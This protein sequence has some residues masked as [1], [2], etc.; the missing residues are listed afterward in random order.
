[1]K[2]E[3]SP[4][5]EQEAEVLEGLKMKRIVS[6]VVI[7]LAV[8][9]CAGYSQTIT[10]VVEDANTGSGIANARIYVVNQNRE[11]FSAQDGSYQ[12]NNVN[13]NVEAVICCEAFGYESRQAFTLAGMQG[14]VFRDF[15]LPPL[16]PGTISGVIRDAFDDPVN[17]A[18]ISAYS[19][20]DNVIATSTSDNNGEY[21]L[22]LPHGHAYRIAAVSDPLLGES[23]VTVEAEGEHTLDIVIADS[24]GMVTGPD[25]YGYI[26]VENQDFHPLAPVYNWIAN[27][28]LEGGPGTR[29]VIP[30]EPNEDLNYIIDLPFTFTFYGLDYDHITACENGM[31]AFGA[32]ADTTNP[33]NFSNTRIPS[34][35]GGPPA[36][37]APFWED[38]R[39]TLT[40]LSHY[41][42]EENGT[43]IIEWYNS[44]QWP[45]G[46]TFETF[47]VVLY[48]PAVYQ[49]PNGDGMLLYQYDDANDLGNASVGIEDHTE[50]IGLEICFFDNTGIGSYAPTAHPIVDGSALVFY[51]P[52]ASVS[53][54][55]A[56]NPPG[57]L[58]NVTV[59]S[60]G[61]QTNCAQD[62]SFTLDGISSGATEILIQAAG[63]E[64][65][66]VPLVVD[67]L[68]HVTD[69][70]AT[71]W[72]L[73]PP[74]NAQGE[75]IGLEFRLSWTPPFEELDDFRSLYRIYA[76]GVFFH[77]TTETFYQFTPPPEQTITY[78]I[79]AIY[80][81]GESAHSNSVVCTAPSSFT[82]PLRA[83]Y[84]ELIST[85]LQPIN[86]NASVVF[87]GVQYLVIVYQSNG[88]IYIPPGINTIGNIDV[89][90]GYQLFCSQA[91][92]VTIQGNAVNPNMEFSL[93]SGLWNWLAFPFD[94]PIT[95]TTALSEITNNVI[96]MLTD[97]GRLWVP[98]FINTVGNMVPGEGYFIFVNTNVTFHFNPGV[99]RLPVDY[100]QPAIEQIPGA[101]VP[102][103]LPYVVLVHLS[104]QLRLNRPA[105]LEVYDGA[106][107]VG[108]NIVMDEDDLVPVIAWQGSAEYGVKGFT[109][110]NPIMVIA[111]AADGCEL[112]IS[113]YSNNLRFGE[114]AYAELV[115]DC[116]SVAL[117]DGFTVNPAFPNPFN[118]TLTVPFTLPAA[119]EVEFA[120]FNLLGQRV[121]E[122]RQTFPAGDHHFTFD[123]AS[124]TETLVSG[125]YLVQVQYEGQIQTQKVML[126][127]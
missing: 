30:A 15:S 103:G 96:I 69:V 108:K 54:T 44:R 92:E 26:A 88:G 10:G 67:D 124:T 35:P 42:D 104:D 49:T 24:T 4:Y 40:N 117:L 91:S 107:M 53:G 81:G 75:N 5:T 61:V 23:Y 94:H 71:L 20:A 50:T 119:G 72:Q 122:V 29:V 3:S 105:Y 99:F 90:Q 82:L 37:V 16:E 25:E 64:S 31:F 114:G 66:V 55:V 102:T 85:Y 38:F 8:L 112:A 52:G 17:N 47:E 125:V 32:L 98:P 59:S 83:N 60:S 70:E 73:L 63:Y 13:L 120:L 46:A 111:Q 28:P 62:G 78:W 43:F 101:P 76:N 126:L 65:V 89:H 2:Q 123:A 115:L 106:K 87:G 18:S 9:A 95:A 97:D 14:M 77:E 118:P 80:D 51:V 7:V 33:R 93:R 79:T 27:D 48:D 116:K 84:F 45:D 127:K 21:S 41:Y 34:S 57:N 56:M 6:V 19:I 1:M 58:A 68:D 100:S 12:I 74:L 22:Q 113:E 36:M 39:A 109:P 11:A 121:H 86:L 110:G